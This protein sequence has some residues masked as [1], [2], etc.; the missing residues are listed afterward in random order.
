MSDWKNVQYKDGKMRTNEGGGGGGGGFSMTK[1]AE[2]T[3]TPSLVRNTYNVI[4][5]LPSGTLSEGF[6]FI[7]F[8]DRYYRD[9]DTQT[10]CGMNGESG[11]V[12]FPASGSNTFNNYRYDRWGW[13]SFTQSIIM[14][15]IDSSSVINFTLYGY[16][17]NPTNVVITIYKIG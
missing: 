9:G 3:L 12:V 13:G 5:S 14:Q 2:Y 6:Y 11:K 10:N 4:L 8:T 15:V 17:Y 1:I 16:G 7:G